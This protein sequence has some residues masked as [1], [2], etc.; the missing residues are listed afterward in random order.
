LKLSDITTRVV[1]HE[2]DV[3]YFTEYPAPIMELIQCSHFT[4][5]NSTIPF[6]GP[7]LYFL[8]RAMGVEQVL[9]IGHAEC[10]TAWYLA[11]AV[12]DN[13]TRFGM[14]GNRYY[15]IDIVQ[16]EKA[17]ENLKDLPAT[18]INMDSMLLTPDTFKDIKFDLIF[19]DG[20]H[21]T[22]HVLHELKT[23]YPQ[24]KGEG[25]GFWIFHDIRGPS[26]E[27]WHILKKMIAEGIYKFEYVIIPEIYG[28]GLF[29]KIEGEDANKR[30]WKD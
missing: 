16:T 13:A 26:E 2:K 8:A 28:M 1:T 22:E 29:R 27:A 5:I 9:E 14:A 21:D 30:Y 25:R 19:Q 20:C 7:M 18:I 4:N 24:L 12:K 17:R 10:Y 11:N 3:E 15:G 23:L 6:F